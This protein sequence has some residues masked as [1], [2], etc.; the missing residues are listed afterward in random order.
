MYCRVKEC[1]VIIC[2]SVRLQQLHKLANCRLCFFHYFFD[3]LQIFADNCK[4]KYAN[5]QVLLPFT[6]IL[7]IWILSKRQLGKHSENAYSSHVRTV[8]S[9]NFKKPKYLLIFQTRRPLI[10]QPLQFSHGECAAEGGRCAS[11]WH[12][13]PTTLISLA[14]RCGMSPRRLVV[15][16][17]SMRKWVLR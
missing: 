14:A 12:Y 7:H 16:N 10:V 9:A 2:W 6:F 1:H 13:F 4:C 15:S 3:L 11:Q 17:E 8:Q 5:A